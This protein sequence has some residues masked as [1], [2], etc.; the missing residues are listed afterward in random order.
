MLDEIERAEIEELKKK[1]RDHD[2]KFKQLDPVIEKLDEE[3][4]KNHHPSPE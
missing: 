1:L 2:E 3:Y 4:R